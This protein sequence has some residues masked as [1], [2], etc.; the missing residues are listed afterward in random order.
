MSEERLHYIDPAHITKKIYRGNN[1]CVPLCHNSSGGHKERK[2]LG[3]RK[4]SFHSF[5]DVKSI[6]GKEWIQKIRRDPGNEF[7]VTKNTKVC[8][9]HFTPSDFI[10]DDQALQCIRRC[11]KSSAV[12]SLFAWTN[13]VNKCMSVTSQKALQPLTID[14]TRKQSTCSSHEEEPCNEVYVE[15]NTEVMDEQK[16]ITDLQK[17]NIELKSKLKETEKQLSRSLF[18]LVDIK[19]DSS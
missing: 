9:E 19:D 4:I 18:R 13:N 6:K 8:S 11:L 17:E 1:C 7:I 14:S 5:L 16:L 3:V 10:H 2:R 15:S 12:R